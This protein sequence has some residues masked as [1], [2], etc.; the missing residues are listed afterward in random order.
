MAGL[1]IKCSET[2]ERIQDDLL[3]MVG[4][5]LKLKANLGRSKV[6]E[7]EGILEQAHPKVFIVKVEEDDGGYRRFSYSYADLLT[8]TVEIS[9]AKT[10]ENILSWLKS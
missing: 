4:E 9:C 1:N 5:K 7:A 10:S 2:I 3:L 6:L 8:R